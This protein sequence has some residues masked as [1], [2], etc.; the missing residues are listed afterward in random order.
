MLFVFQILKGY[1][2]PVLGNSNMKEKHLRKRGFH[3]NALGNAILTSIFL[4]A[5]RNQE[6]R[7]LDNNLVFNDKIF[8]CD[9]LFLDNNVNIVNCNSMNFNQQSQNITNDVSPNIETHLSYL[10]DLRRKILTTPW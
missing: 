1:H 5:I 10:I 2:Y 9:N 6:W 8:T 7:S 3:L 4:N